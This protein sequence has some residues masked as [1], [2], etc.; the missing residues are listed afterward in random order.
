MDSVGALW[1]FEL[2]ICGPGQPGLETESS[3]TNEQETGSTKVR[4]RPGT[5]SHR[6]CSRLTRGHHRW[7][8]TLWEYF[9]KVNIHKLC[10]LGA[11]TASHASQ[12]FEN[13]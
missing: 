5:D 3:V 12:P 1:C 4:P 6:W 9:L 8:E 13:V 10:C 7:G 11:Q 2:R